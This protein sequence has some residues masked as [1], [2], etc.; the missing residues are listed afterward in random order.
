MLHVYINYISKSDIFVVGYYGEDGVRGFGCRWD[1]K[2][3]VA[4]VNMRCSVGW[5]PVRGRTDILV[6]RCVYSERFAGS[7]LIEGS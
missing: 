2:L 4:I 6:V 3:Y 5:F 1:E 7:E